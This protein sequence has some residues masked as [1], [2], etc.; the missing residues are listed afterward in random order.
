MVAY[1]GEATA[2]KL[3]PDLMAAAGVEPDANQGGVGVRQASVFQAGIFDPLAL[4]FDGEDLVFAA[5]FEEKILPVTGLRGGA[6][7]QGHVFL[8]HGSLLDGLGQLGGGLLCAGVDH[9]AADVF[10]QPVDGENV[11]AEGFLQ[12]GGEF[13]FSVQPC[14]L[15]ADDEVFVGIE[16]VHGNL[17]EAIRSTRRGDPCGRP[18]KFG[19]NFTFP[20]WKAQQYIWIPFCNAKWT[21][22]RKGRPYARAYYFIQYTT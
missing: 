6:V 14:G 19:T 16:N 18:V 8:D 15:D 10:V 11:A 5:V 12:G 13:G 21:G 3:H 4:F 22:D 20:E 1:Q 2:G 7:K 9:D 17:R